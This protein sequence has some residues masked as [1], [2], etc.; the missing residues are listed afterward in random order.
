MSYWEAAAAAAASI[1][2][3]SRANSANAAQSAAARR[4]SHRENKRSMLFAG[5]QAKRQMNFQR[6]M[7]DTAHQREVMD[8]KRAGLN[9][10]LSA[11]GGPG[12]S[13]PGGASAQGQ[14]GGTAQARQ[15]DVL[16]PAISSALA[17]RRLSQD[18]KNLKAGEELTK[19]QT[20]KTIQETDESDTRERK[21]RAESRLLDE[22]LPEAKTSGDLYRKGNSDILKLLEKLGITGSSATGIIK[23]FKKGK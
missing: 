23:L 19:K 4:W 13:T 18:I 12:S 1:I 21:I 22:A 5:D 15:E 10:I 8:Y 20:E 3:G 9:P 7:S 2:G 6:K 16:T 11:T 14:S 17:S